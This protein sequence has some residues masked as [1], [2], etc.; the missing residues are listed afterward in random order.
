MKRHALFVGVNDYTDK[1]FKSLRYSLSD[2]TA[3]SG[4]F[5][6]RGFDV[7]VLS[8]PKVDDVLFFM[9]WQR[10]Y[11]SPWGAGNEV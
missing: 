1:T 8:N 11:F 3:L 9:Q 2:A 7:E 5:A 4:E 6:A 10:A